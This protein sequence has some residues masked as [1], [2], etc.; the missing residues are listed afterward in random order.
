MILSVA[1]GTLIK[2]KEFLHEILEELY[3]QRP[4][5]LLIETGSDGL[6]R[7]VRTWTEARG[8]HTMTIRPLW[9][10]VAAPFRRRNEVAMSFLPDVVLSAGDEPSAIDLMQR[11][12]KQ[13]IQVIRI[14][15]KQGREP[16]VRL[17]NP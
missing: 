14:T 11:A 12:L 4:I 10:L 1:G 9:G 2:E 5:E 16:Y 8:V 3:S 17:I 15:Q 6:E 13:K 7:N